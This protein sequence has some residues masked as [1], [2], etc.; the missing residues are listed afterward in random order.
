MVEVADAEEEVGLR[1][2]FLGAVRHA[3]QRLAEHTTS[4]RSKLP[5]CAQRGG[6]SSTGSQLSAVA[7]IEADDAADIAVQLD[8]GSGCRRGRAGPS[9]L[10]RE[11]ECRPCGL[12]PREGVV[13][14]LAR[15]GGEAPT[16]FVPFPHHAR[17]ALE[18]LRRPRGLHVPVLAIG[19]SACRGRWK[20][21]SRPRYPRR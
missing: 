7:V 20:D 8:E 21:R 14:G 6:G 19:R 18:G 17:I 9:T 2:R 3:A 13:P 11:E 5:H 10:G 16:P 4:G 15:P 12:N 1:R